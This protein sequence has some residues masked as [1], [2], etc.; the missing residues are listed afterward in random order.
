MFPQFGWRRE[1][2]PRF[3][4]YYYYYYY[5]L[6]DTITRRLQPHVVVHY[7]QLPGHITRYLS[8]E[9]FTSSTTMVPFCGCLI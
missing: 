9:S 8:T 3:D 6:E 2:W 1:N 7:V 5:V 4:Y